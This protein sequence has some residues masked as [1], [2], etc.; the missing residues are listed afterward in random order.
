MDDTH[1]DFEIFIKNYDPKTKKLTLEI[2]NIAE[3][4]VEALTL[5]I[6]QQENIEI[7]GT[8]TNIVG[9]LDSNEYTTADFTAVPKEGEIKVNIY[10]SDAI[11]E[12]RTLEKSISFDPSYFV[13]S[14]DAAGTAWYIYLLYVVIVAGVIYYF[15]DR[16]QKKKREHKHRRGSATLG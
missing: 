2:L 14:E 10:Y 7:Q 12:R 3:S 1:A 16:R 15:Y 13:S 8:K 11:N 9:D 4:D 5:E 6:P